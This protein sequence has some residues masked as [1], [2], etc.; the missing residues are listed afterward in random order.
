MSKTTENKNSGPC[1]GID[2]GTTYSCVGVWQNDRVEIIANDQGERTTPSWV[3]FTD[4]ER[5][6]GVAAKNQ[7]SMNPNN[8]IYD[9]KR[10]IGRKFDDPVVQKFINDYPF[11]VKCDD[12]NKPIF[13]IDYKNSTK[14][15]TAEEMGAMVLTKM[16]DVA[17]TFLGETVYNAVVTVPAYFNDSQRQATKDAGAIAGLNILR[18]INEPTAAAIAYGLDKMCDGE[19]NVLIVDLGGGTYDVTLLCIDAGVLNVKATCG[20]TSL[21]GVDF[22]DRMV[23][24]F[25]EKFKKEKG[26]DISNNPRA[27]RRLQTAC[28]RA[29]R[30][31]STNTEAAIE[32]DSLFEGVDYYTK[33]TRALFEQLNMDLFK[34]CMK[35]VE[36]VLSDAKMDKTKV[37]EIVLVGGSTRIPK[38]QQL[39]QDYF[40]GKKLNCS[41]NPDEAVAYGA[42]VQAAILSGVKDKKISNILLLDVAPLSLGLETSGQIMTVLIPR[43]TTLPTKKSQVFSTYADNQP[44]VSIQVFE[45]E[46]TM[47]KDNNCLGNFELVGIE[48]AKRGVPRVEVTFD[49]D[50]NGIMQVSAFDKSTGK[51]SKIT[52]TNDD[53]RLTAEEIEKMI[54][55][56]KEMAKE[57][58]TMRE[59]AETKNDLEQYIYNLLQSLDESKDK[60]TNHDIETVEE[61]CNITTQFMEEN[62]QATKEELEQARSELEITTK[63][64]MSRNYSKNNSYKSYGSRIDDDGNMYENNGPTVYDCDSDDE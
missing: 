28:E 32:I 2:L 56:A 58:R 8:T 23:K 63:S 43:N 13:E 1:I 17:E 12:N 26:K 49:V 38:V 42:A 22:D 6:I 20:N 15:F 50:S 48:P 31:L 16:K 60:M 35:P 62:S 9:S 5:L 10:L 36:Q 37:N 40:N 19:K 46:R 54:Q 53:D 33:C 3:A 39:L 64:I 18:I 30:T 59:R 25:S 29:K 27:L 55:I 61:A 7:A 4:T 57:D 14:S 21:G 51:S 52:I 47:T 41:I 44:G 34:S 11:K 45:G 24:H